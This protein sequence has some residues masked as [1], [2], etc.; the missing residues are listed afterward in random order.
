MI[1]PSCLRVL[2]WVFRK[3]PKSWAGPRISDRKQESK[4]NP[5]PAC[6]HEVSK[7]RTIGS[8]RSWMPHGWFTSFWEPWLGS[9]LEPWGKWRA[10]VG[11]YDIEAAGVRKAP[12]MYYRV[13]NDLQPADPIWPWLKKNLHFKKTFF[14]GGIMNVAPPWTLLLAKNLHC[15]S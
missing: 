2:C 3:P 9:F 6:F 10:G 13:W 14:W 4:R 7:G 15:E 12:S 5:C 8:I 11:L 1:W